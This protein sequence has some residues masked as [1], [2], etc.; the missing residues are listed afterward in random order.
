MTA[1]RRESPAGQFLGESAAIGL[2]GGVIGASVGVIVVVSVSAAKGST[3]VLDTWM[4]FLA[5]PAGA[6]VGL[7]AGMYPAIRAARM[8]PVEALRGRD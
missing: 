2:V 8:E 6:L 5:P 4:P 7:L 3:P 1:S